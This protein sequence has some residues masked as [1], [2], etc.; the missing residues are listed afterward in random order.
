MA[1]VVCYVFVVLLTWF[2]CVVQCVVVTPSTPSVLSYLQR[3]QVSTATAQHTLLQFLH[4]HRI[5]IGSEAGS[6]RAALETEQSILDKITTS[7]DT[8]PVECRVTLGPA[9]SG[10][11]CVAPCG[12]SGSQKWVQFSVLNRLR[13]KDPSQ[14]TTCPT[15][16]QS[17]QFALFTS[18]GGLQAASLGALLDSPIVLRSL[19]AATFV[20]ILV[21]VNASAWLGRLLV[22]RSL[23]QLVSVCAT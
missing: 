12:C 2:V 15:C 19:L 3:E 14:W 20:I 4:R 5:P 6:L 21:V 16:R 13:R 10:A 23:W 7:T 22:S 1:T 17:F 9:P 8:H 11:K 18:Y